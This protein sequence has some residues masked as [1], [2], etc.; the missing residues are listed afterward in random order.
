[1]SFREDSSPL[2]GRCFLSLNPYEEL[3]RQRLK[4]SYWA[5]NISLLRYSGLLL[6]SHFEAFSTTAAVVST[7]TRHRSYYRR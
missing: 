2:Y 4:V 6:W 7:L 3:G 1:M 5:A